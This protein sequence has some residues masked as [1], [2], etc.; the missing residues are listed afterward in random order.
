MKLGRKPAYSFGGNLPL[1]IVKA[2]RIDDERNRERSGDFEHHLMPDRERFD[3]IE[4]MTVVE[5]P[6]SLTNEELN[7]FEKTVN[8]VLEQIYSIYTNELRK[9]RNRKLPDGCSMCVN[10]KK[11]KPNEEMMERQPYCRDCY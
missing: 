9:M 4:F 10:C 6:R 5:C 7:V 2:R 1:D 3:S 8:R 11:I